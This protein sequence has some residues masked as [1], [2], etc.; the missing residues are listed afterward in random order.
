LTTST[1]PIQPEEDYKIS[2]HLQQ[3]FDKFMKSGEEL[4]I[5]L[6]NLMNKG[7]YSK[8]SQLARESLKDCQN[9]IKDFKIG[10]KYHL[11]LEKA[12]SDL[13]SFLALL[14]SKKE[15]QEKS[16]KTTTNESKTY[17]ENNNISASTSNSN[18]SNK[19]YFKTKILSEEI[20]ETAT[21][22]AEAEMSFGDFPKT[23]YGFEKAYAS[24]K[25]RT[26]MFFN[27]LKFITGKTLS[28]FYQSSEMSYQTL[29]GILQTLKEHCNASQETAKVGVDIL[30]NLT[31]TKNFNLIRKFLKK[32]DKE[33]LRKLFNELKEN[34]GE[35]LGDLDLEKLYL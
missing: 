33:D 27:Y 22:I 20:R 32:S 11:Q 21:K 23:S 35:Y 2:P 16:E 6:S 28:S 29:I 34:Y 17:S 24:M 5:Q 14:A 30:L 15:D 12:I 1:T 13:N 9:F 26:D 3:I 4:K 7:D 19:K 18:D 10:S 8:A 25:K 31:K